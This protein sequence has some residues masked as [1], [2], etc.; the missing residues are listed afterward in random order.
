MC[1]WAET[2]AHPTEKNRTDKITTEEGEE[3]KAIDT[4]SL[5]PTNLHS[6]VA[7]KKPSLSYLL[8][9]G[10]ICFLVWGSRCGLRQQERVSSHTAP[11]SSSLSGGPHSSGHAGNIGVTVVGSCGCVRRPTGEKTTSQVV[12]Y[13]FSILLFPLF[14]F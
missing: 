4:V 6:L 10:L 8:R 3:T 14:L 11:T 1:L 13:L 7:M 12:Q 9:G 2:C 5:N